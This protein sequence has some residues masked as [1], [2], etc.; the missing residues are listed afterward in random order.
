VTFEKSL[1]VDGPVRLEVT[2]GSGK[3][4]IRH[5][6]PGGVR[7]HGDVRASGFLLGR[8]ERAA[9]D[10]A[11][12]PPVEQV[13]NLIS[14]GESRRPR[15][16]RNVSISYTIETPEDTRIQ[17]KSGSGGVEVEGVRGP[18]QIAVGSG[19]AQVVN[20]GDD[21]ALTV[22]SGSCRVGHV[23]GRVTFTVG[24]GTAT[25]EDLGDEIRGQSGSGSMEIDRP[26]GRVN[27]KSG[28]GP[29]RISGAAQDVRA[30]TGSGGLDIQGNPAVGTFWDL[31]ASSGN[32][33]LTVPGDASFALTAQTASGSIRTDVPISIE[34]ESRRSLRARVGRGEASVTL[35]TGSGGI[36]LRPGGKS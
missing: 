15:G 35:R 13:G 8:D 10:V 33:T 32:I 4:V 23:A 19:A 28:S 1:K 18:A 26:R 2:T 3:I 29:I 25:F 31:N 7:I 17:A 20:I 6:A 11:A 30:A 36:Q 16:L 9:Q 22:G 5:G 34:E 21:V 24:S 12:N 27:V 14:V